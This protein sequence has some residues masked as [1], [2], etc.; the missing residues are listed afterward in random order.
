MMTYSFIADN[1]TQRER[2]IRIGLCSFSWQVARPLSYPI[3]A[4]LFDSGGYV[5]VFSASLI[6]YV[7]ASIIGLISLWNFKENKQ[8]HS[9]SLSGRYW[10]LSFLYASF[11]SLKTWYLLATLL[12]LSKLSSRRGKT[13]KDS[14]WSRWWSWCWPT[15]WPSTPSSTASSCTLRE[16]L[17]GRLRIT[18]TSLWSRYLALI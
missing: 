10:K 1:S 11:S 2:M 17:S 13:T 4:W 16:C 14:T 8:K 12:S 7:I 3:G 5:R 9:T 6:L 15:W 18:L